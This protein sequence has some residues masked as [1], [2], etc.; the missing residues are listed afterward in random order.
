VLG[1]VMDRWCRSRVR[2]GKCG[3]D[4]HVLRANAMA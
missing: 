2:W 4:T 1:A 3:I